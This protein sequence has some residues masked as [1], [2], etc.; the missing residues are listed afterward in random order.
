MMLLLKK[1]LNK[2]LN[3]CFYLCLLAA[4][5][6]GVQVFCFTSFRIP[7]NSMEPALLPGDNIIV[8]KMAGGARLF[9]IFAALNKEE[10]HIKRV[11]GTGSF[12]RNDVLVFNFPYPNGWNNIRFDV[13]QYYVKRCIGLPGDTL[14]I[15]NGF[16]HI[17]GV[18]EA[19]GNI[20][21]QQFIANLTDS[22]SKR[23]VMRSYPKDKQLGWTIQAFGP[24]YLPAKGQSVKMNRVNGVLYHRL[25]QWEQKK[26]V[27]LKE[28]GEVYLE[29]SLI[30]SY[31]FKQ[32]Y[33]FMAGDR[34]KDSQDS[35]YWGPLPEEFIVGRADYVWMSRKKKDRTVRWER[36]MK[37][38]K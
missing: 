14:E 2:L 31:C 34:L 22:T 4:L 8:N 16:F 32:N 3:V 21:M 25:I 29:D 26:T 6:A 27:L 19:L 28:N 18:Q 1:I 5:W 20:E 35:R 24:L 37:K 36:F 9:D 23:T 33:Y 30:T 13:M 7:T 17:N 10:F 15:R 12:E 11:P 38:I